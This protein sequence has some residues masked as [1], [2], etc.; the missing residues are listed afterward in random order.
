MAD[1]EDRLSVSMEL[2]SPLG[3]SFFPLWRGDP[4]RI[5]NKTGVHS[6]PGVAGSRV[7]DQKV[8]A[9]IWPLTLLFDGPDND[10]DAEEFRQTYIKESGKWEIF[11]PTKG[12]LLLTKISYGEQVQPVTSGGITIVETVWIEGL[13]DSEEETAAQIQA[14]ADFAAQQ[15]NFTA[16]NQFDSNAKQ[17]TPG[18][19][20]SIITTIGK[21]ITAIQQK[22][23]LVENFSLLDPQILAIAAAIENTLTEPLIDTSKLAGQMQSYVQIF[24]LGQVNATDGVTMYQDFADE[25]LTIVPEE[26]TDNNLSAIAVTELVASAALTAAGQSSLIGGIESRPQAVSTAQKMIGMFDE[27]TQQ[28]DEIQTLYQDKPI[29]L[30]YFSQTNSYGDNLI[31]TSEATRFLLTSVFALP[32][33]RRII[34]KQDESIPQIAK[35]EYGNIGDDTDQIANI[36]RLISSNNLC[37]NDGWWL[38]AGTGLLIYQAA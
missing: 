25:V 10:L 23:A 30:A 26:P 22:L 31:L 35:N 28:L 5:S 13:P 9:T 18:Q 14:Q 7:Q 1:W 32:A 6:I 20:Q 34:L 38:P 11:H 4:I 15:A 3:N 8:N 27:I 2:I 33:E 19:K 24:T 12:P 16:S 29:D 36:K 21:T 37:G 17:D